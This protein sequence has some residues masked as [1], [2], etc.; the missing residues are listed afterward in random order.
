MLGPF[1]GV[2]EFFCSLLSSFHFFSLQE[3]CSPI[4]K[5]ERD[6]IFEFFF[7]NFKFQK[8]RV[9]QREHKI[10]ERVVRGKGKTIVGHN[11]LIHINWF[12]GALTLF[13]LFEGNNIDCPITNFLGTWGT[14]QS[15]HLFGPPIP[16][17]KRKCFPMAHL[18]T[19]YT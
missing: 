6:Y 10:K 11:S 2:C 15:K 19:L 5:R 17:L 4:P 13:F 1:M 8:E 12:M 9:I 7:V 14:P 3:V 16:K 18:F